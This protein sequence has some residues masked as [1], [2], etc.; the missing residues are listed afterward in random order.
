MADLLGSKDLVWDYIVDAAYADAARRLKDPNT[1][2]VESYPVQSF[3]VDDETG[4]HPWYFKL[5][6]SIT[7]QAVYRRDL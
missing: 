3:S 4:R 1:N 6:I 2:L 7:Y 5:Y